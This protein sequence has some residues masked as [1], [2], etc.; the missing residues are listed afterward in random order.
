VVAREKAPFDCVPGAP[1]KALAVAMEVPGIKTRCSRPGLMNGCLDYQET[2]LGGG[3]ARVAGKA[4]MPLGRV[5]IDLRD[6]KPKRSWLRRDS[7][8]GLCR[9]SSGPSAAHW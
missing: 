2:I 4:L 7:V 5:V 1:P 3:S 9:S 6:Q 8:T